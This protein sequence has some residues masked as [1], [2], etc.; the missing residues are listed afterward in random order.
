MRQYSIDGHPD[1]R[2]ST[3]A[4]AIQIILAIRIGVPIPF[5]QNGCGEIP[6]HCV[7]AVGGR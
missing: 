3:F 2:R 6:A 7:N 5:T 4:Y 1:M